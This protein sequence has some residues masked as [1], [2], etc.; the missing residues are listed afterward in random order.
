[1]KL[2]LKASTHKAEVHI[3]PKGTGQRGT[4]VIIGSEDHADE[5]AKIL[6]I[7]D[8]W[9][10]TPIAVGGKWAWAAFNAGDRLTIAEFSEDLGDE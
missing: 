9:K 5:I 10:P 1:M 2:K 4:L 6:N 3:S 8:G 7:P